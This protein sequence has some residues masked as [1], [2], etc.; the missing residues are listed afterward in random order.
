MKIRVLLQHC[1][2]V[3]F[4]FFCIVFFVVVTVTVAVVVV[5]TRRFIRVLPADVGVAL[6]STVTILHYVVLTQTRTRD[7]AVTSSIAGPKQQLRAA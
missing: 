7:S 5:E 3:R 6:K 2:L 4:R 1:H